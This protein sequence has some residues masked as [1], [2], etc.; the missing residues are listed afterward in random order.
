MDFWLL[1]DVSSEKRNAFSK[2]LNVQKY[3]KLCY[4]AYDLVFMRTCCY[5]VNIYVVPLGSL[6]RETGH[7]VP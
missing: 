6:E 3:L 4:C 1:Y 7:L 2:L 5:V